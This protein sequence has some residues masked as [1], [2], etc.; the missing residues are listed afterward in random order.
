LLLVVAPARC[1]DARQ[2]PEPEPPQEPNQAQPS[3]VAFDGQRA[4]DWLLYQCEMGPRHPG[5]EGI[6]RLRSAIAAHADSLGLVCRSLGYTREDPYA[7]GLL[8]IRNLVVSTRP[9]GGR[10]LWLGAHY[11]TRPRCDRD[12]DPAKRG[13][14]LLGANDGAS[15]V[16]VLLHLAELVAANPPPRGIDLIFFDAEDYGREGDSQ[17]YCL[18]SSY[19]AK[20]WRDFGSPLAEGQPEGLIVLDMIGKAGLEV[21]MEQ[22][23]LLYAE[24][25]THLVFTRARELDLPA[26]R[27]VP[28]PAV[29]DDHVPFLAVGIAAVDLIDFAYP[30]WHTTQDLP[31]AC[32]PASLAQVGTLVADIIY[33]PL[34]QP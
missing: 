7:A 23:S 19:L 20:H 9:L 34:V 24:R 17:F 31:E 4:M 22:Y 15:G 14:P 12:P 13:Q 30:Q 27:A 10:R 21:T 11:D 28:G 8:E 1:L 26:F 25:W 2:G 16:A 5:S 6:R 33:R 3:P 32:S 29:Q 18:G